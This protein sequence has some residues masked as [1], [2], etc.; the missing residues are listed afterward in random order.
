MMNDWIA[1]L[2]VGFLGAGHCMGMCGGIASAMSL[3]SNS[4]NRTTFI[5]LCYNLGRLLTYCIAGALIGGTVSSIAE[6]ADYN[7]AF[8]YLRLLAAIFMILLALYLGKWWFGLLFIEKM[9]QH[10][11]KHLSPLG[12]KLLPLQSPWHAIPFGMVWGWLPCGLVYSMLTWSAV[13]GDAVSG[14]MIMLAFGL[15]TLP[16]MVMIGFGATK[17][18]SLQRSPTFRQIGALLLLAYGIYSGYDALILLS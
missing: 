3:G 7:H 8:V 12:N 17:I 2:M 10:L 11:W 4:S 1:A 15:G 6:V 14:A 16:S 18:Q 9:G 13:A 5:T